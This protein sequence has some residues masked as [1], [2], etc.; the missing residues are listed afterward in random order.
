[1]RPSRFLNKRIGNISE[2]CDYDY[3]VNC[4]GLGSQDLADDLNMEPVSGHLL[5]VEAPWVNQALIVRQRNE[6]DPDPTYIVPK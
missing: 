5:R 4:T 2:L 6:D 1:L 3:I